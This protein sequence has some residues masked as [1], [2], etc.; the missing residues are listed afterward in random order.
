MPDLQFAVEGDFAHDTLDEGRF[1]R[2]VLAHEGDLLA[3][4]DGECHIME[5]VKVAV[6][7]AQVLGNDGV[8]AAAGSGR[9][10]E[11]HA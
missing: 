2:T 9:E 4:L 8:V 6:V 1:A 7:L 11:P 3:A 10:L 5:D